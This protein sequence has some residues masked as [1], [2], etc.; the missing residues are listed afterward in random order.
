MDQVQ[1]LGANDGNHVAL[2]PNFLCIG[3]RQ[4]ALAEQAVPI[5]HWD[6]SRCAQ[7][8]HGDEFRTSFVCAKHDNGAP[9]GHFRRDVAAE[10]AVNDA[11][12]FR[13]ERKCHE[14]EVSETD[15]Y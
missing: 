9:L 2:C 13:L 1:S 5:F 7:R 14:S 11:A 12:R 4:R 8:Y 3:I 15:A 10:V 6:W